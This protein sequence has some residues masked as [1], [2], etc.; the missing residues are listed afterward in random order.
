MISMSIIILPCEKKML[1]P[2]LNTKH[3]QRKKGRKLP[4]AIHLETLMMTKF[5]FRSL[6]I[7]IYHI[8]PNTTMNDIQ[9]S[10]GRVK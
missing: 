3:L 5:I 6:L 1:I 4:P 9:K 10:Q 7:I 2:I 8:I